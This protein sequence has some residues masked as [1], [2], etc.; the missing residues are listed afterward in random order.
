MSDDHIP[1]RVATVFI[2]RKRRLFSALDETHYLLLPLCPGNS[3]S[4][5]SLNLT[6]YPT[7]QSTFDGGGKP[8]RCSRPMG[9]ISAV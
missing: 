7:T 9:S 4:S 2:L 1:T 5:E 3:S 6:S 8:S